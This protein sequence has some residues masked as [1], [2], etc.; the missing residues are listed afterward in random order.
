[1]QRA[2]RSTTVVTEASVNL[3]MH[4]ATIAYDPRVSSAEALLAAINV[5]G[6]EARLPAPAADALAEDEAREIAQRAEY[7]EL[8]VKSIAALALGLIAM[9]LSMPL[10]AAG[11]HGRHAAADPLQRWVMAWTRS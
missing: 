1:V 7:R 3:M 4:S 8:L 10:M 11:D 5:T 6:D 9:V 2:L